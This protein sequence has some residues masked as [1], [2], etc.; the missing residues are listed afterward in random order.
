[1]EYKDIERISNALKERA[2]SNKIPKDFEDRKMTELITKRTDSIIIGLRRIGK[3]TLLEKIVQQESQITGKILTLENTPLEISITDLDGPNESMKTFQSVSMINQEKLSQILFLKMDS[4]EFI[5]QSDD[6]LQQT[7]IKIRDYITSHDIK[8]VLIDEIQVIPNWIYLLKDIKD[9]KN[10]VW[11]MCTGSNA[12][13]LLESTEHGLGRFTPKFYGTLSLEE[14]YSLQK[15]ID[16]NLTEDDYKNKNHLSRYINYFHFPNYNEEDYFREVP[17][18]VIEKS[19]GATQKNKTMLLK[20]IQW[21]ADRPGSIIN[22]SSIS[23]DTGITRQYVNDYINIMESGQLLWLLHNRKSPGGNKKGYVLIPGLF[24]LYKFDKSYDT[25]SDIEQG[26]HFENF[27]LTQ[28]L[29]LTSSLNERLNW[30]YILDHSITSGAKEI[31]FIYQNVGFEVKRTWN[32]NFIHDYLSI[33]GQNNINTFYFIYM[34]G[35]EEIENHVVD[36]EGKKITFKFIPWYKL[37]DKK[38]KNIIKE[39]IHVH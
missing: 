33:A 4:L 29:S 39:D 10:D 24:H 17:T 23:K 6:Q 35:P 13:K 3:T 12:S 22:A 20:V 31:D 34:D 36:F 5:S 30:E 32:D 18:A 1:M 37:G 25:L 38:T 9:L 19:F 15:N 8:I 21:L 27:V 16:P 7:A 26:L 2:I 11:V 28:L 14:Y